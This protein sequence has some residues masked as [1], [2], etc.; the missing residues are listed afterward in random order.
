MSLSYDKPYY[1]ITTTSV[2]R[3]SKTLMTKAGININQFWKGNLNSYNRALK[4]YKVSYRRVWNVIEDIICTGSV[5]RGILI[6]WVTWDKI[7]KC[8]GLPFPLTFFVFSIIYCIWRFDFIF[9]DH[10]KKTWRKPHVFVFKLIK[11]MC[12]AII[13]TFSCSFKSLGIVYS[14][15]NSKYE[16]LFN[17]EAFYMTVLSLI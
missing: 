7:W 11:L 13:W 2:A 14:F 9:S 1:P 5:C 15:L 10:K 4:E 16:C 6:S 17:T 8:F 3:W 12:S